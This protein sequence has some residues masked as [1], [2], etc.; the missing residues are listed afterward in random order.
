M[1]RG[2]R[3]RHAVMRIYACKLVALMLDS[4]WDALLHRCC[5]VR[6]IGLIFL[7]TELR[8]HSRQLTRGNDL[9]D[10]LYLLLHVQ[11]GRVGTIPALKI[12][13]ELVRY[14]VTYL[15]FYFP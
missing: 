3:R 2:L 4:I 14:H 12:I 9:T 15:R 13:S 10:P 8:L 5:C 11:C 7:L 1:A 6:S